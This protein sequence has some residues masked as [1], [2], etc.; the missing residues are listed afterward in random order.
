M[1][2]PNVTPKNLALGVIHAYSRLQKAEKAHSHSAPKSIKKLNRAQFAAQTASSALL[3]LISTLSDKGNDCRKD[4]H[5]SIL[6][7]DHVVTIDKSY[8]N[9]WAGRTASYVKVSRI[10]QD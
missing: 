10:W 3:N 7:G 4:G 5:V 6:V 8:F 2:N 1:S 9:E